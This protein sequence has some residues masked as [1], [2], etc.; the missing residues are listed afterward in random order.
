VLAAICMLL[1]LI[2]NLYPVPEGPYGKLPYI[3]LLY[4]VCGLA[5][6]AVRSRTRS[7]APL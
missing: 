1:A 7:A 3:Y 4:L 2:G 6:F 5:W